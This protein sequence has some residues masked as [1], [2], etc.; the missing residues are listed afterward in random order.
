MPADRGTISVLGHD[1]SEEGDSIRRRV[2]VLTENVA[3]YESLSARTNLAFFGALHGMSPSSVAQ[4]TDE[5]LTFFELT[6][7]ADQKIGAFSKGMKQRIALARA[8]LHDP[9]IVYLDEPTA[10]LDPDSARAVTEL[11]K[12]LSVVEQR[13]VFLA[14]HNLYE[15]QNLCSRV[16]MLDQGQKLALDSPVNLMANLGSCTGLTIT[17]LE[18]PNPRLTDLIAAQNSVRELKPEGLTFRLQLTDRAT[19]P[20]LIKMI[21]VEGGRLYSVVP[22][23][24]SLVDVYFTLRKHN[25]T[26]APPSEIP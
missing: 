4:K 11:I 18:Q 1:P 23:A 16:M 6:G 14:T 26:L 17:F 7:V 20:D 2:G 15:A 13:T 10:N 24:K 25:S 8:L 19:L 12:R 22:E 5:L 21:A 9:E 3:L